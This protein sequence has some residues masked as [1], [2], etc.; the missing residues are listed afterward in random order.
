[1]NKNIDNKMK[2]HTLKKI[3][4]GAALVVAPIVVSG[5]TAEVDSLKSAPVSEF[6]Q[7][8]VEYHA[9]SDGK[10]KSRINI[11]YNLPLKTDVYGFMEFYG[12]D[13]YFGKN[14]MYTPI[15]L[16]KG[17]GV[18]IESTHASFL[19]T[20]VGFGL[21]Y[22]LF[23]KDGFASLKALPLVLG[24]KVP[25]SIDGLQDAEGHIKSKAIVGYVLSKTFP[26]TEDF[27]VNLS[28]F[29]DMAFDAKKGPMWDYGEIDAVAQVKTGVGQF[30]FGA[31][32]N[33]NVTGKFAPDTKFRV[34]AAY[35][36]K[37]LYN[38]RSKTG[39]HVKK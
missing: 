14:M 4:I 36:P 1:L 12:K 10:N 34:R 25:M 32:F 31:G 33:Q 2:K 21:E 23:F 37:N 16:V 22:R 5:Q 13:G 15:D 17:L 38:S 11:F 27:D 18:K 7:S 28:A 3:G 39:H 24:K 6:S 35:H 20:Q 30:D 9:Q 19:S 26:I 29:G 8:S